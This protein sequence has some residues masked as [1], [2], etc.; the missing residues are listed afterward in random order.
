MPRS[1]ERN[2]EMSKEAMKLALEAAYLAGFNAS[3]EGY[4]GEYPFRDHDAHPEQDV[5]WMQERDK[6][7]KQAL[8]EQPAQQ[9]P[10]AWMPIET[11][12]KDVMVLVCLPRQMNIVVRAWYNSIHN[13][14]QTDYEGE[15]GITRPMY[16]H[17][18]DLWH[19]IPPL[20][21]TPPQRTW[22]G[23]TDREID[24]LYCEHHDEYGCQLSATGYERAIEA[25]LREKNA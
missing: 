6:H 10:V 1:N 5:D 17:E 14:W 13:F 18:G 22:V 8:A 7:I 15:G 24:D 23:L 4:N 11:A 20:Y 21:T 12:P 3:G 2:D 16:F 9:E 19:P 25:K